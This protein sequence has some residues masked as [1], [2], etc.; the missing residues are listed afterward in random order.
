MNNPAMLPPLALPF[1]VNGMLARLP[2]A[3]RHYLLANG[4]YVGLVGATVLAH[5]SEAISAV[6]FPLDCVISLTAAGSARNSLGVGLVGNEGMLG[7]ELILGADSALLHA[8]VQCPGTAL[9]V[10]RALFTQRLAQSPQLQHELKLALQLH[11]QQLAQA[12][13]CARFHLV[14]GRLA[15][16]LLLTHDRMPGNAFHITH[17]FL[18][19]MLGVRR[20]GI[21]MA[22]TELQRLGVISYRRGDI[23]VLDRAGLEAAACSCHASQGH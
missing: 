13:V 8:Q 16:W 3:D 20:V 18:A 22:A 2:A 1:A 12:A 5:C 10:A 7:N 6:Y 23:T 17:E 19:R 9:C 11:M 14:A 21:T 15:R 4:E